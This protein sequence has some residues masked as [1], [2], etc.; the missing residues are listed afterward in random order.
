MQMQM[1]TEAASSQLN[2]KYVETL[3]SDQPRSFK[4][5][6][7]YVYLSNVCLLKCQL[8]S[9]GTST[10]ISLPNSFREAFN[11]RKCSVTFFNTCPPKLHFAYEGIFFFHMPT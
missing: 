9:E 11:V 8:M 4:G 1:E 7:V 3:P 2:F 10:P 5:K 6:F